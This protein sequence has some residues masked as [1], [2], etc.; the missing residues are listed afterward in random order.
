[1]KRL[2]VLV[3]VVGACCIAATATAS[4]A[5]VLVVERVPFTISWN[6]ITLD[7]GGTTLSLSGSTTSTVTF[8]ETMLPD[9][10][11]HIVA[12]GVEKGTLSAIGSDGTTY[13]A[14]HVSGGASTG[15]AFGDTASTSQTAESWILKPT[16]G[17]KTVV[18]HYVVGITYTPAGTTASLR[19]GGTFCIP[20]Y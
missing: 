10:T 16:N 14:T 4:A 9:G 19:E 8:V 11:T 1:M 15:S 2:S 18:F 17:G 6:G 12:S 13:Q 20:G 7:C 3:A 5:G